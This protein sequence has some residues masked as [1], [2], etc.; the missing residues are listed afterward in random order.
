MNKEI[1][2]GLVIGL[3]GGMLVCATCPKV[4]KAVVEGKEKVLSC[5]KKLKKQA[6]KKLNEEEKASE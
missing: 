1:C 2:F 6:Q 4:K 3:L 5:A